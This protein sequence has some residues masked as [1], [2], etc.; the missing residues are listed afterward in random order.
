MKPLKKLF[1][2]VSADF[3]MADIWIECA[4]LHF[5]S[6]FLLSFF[7]NFLIYEIFLSIEHLETILGFENGLFAV[8]MLF[9]K[10]T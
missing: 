1:F 5:F 8:L 7:L 6:K 9:G 3:L 2:F 10:H 4:L